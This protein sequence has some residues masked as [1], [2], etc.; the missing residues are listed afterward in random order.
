M[1]NKNEQNA[2]ETTTNVEATENATRQVVTGVTFDAETTGDAQSPEVEAEAEAG[3]PAEAAPNVGAAATTEAAADPAAEAVAAAMGDVVPKKQS[4]KAKLSSETTA[5]TDDVVPDYAAL[6]VAEQDVPKYEKLRLRF[7]NLGRLETSQVF[8]RG[9]VVHELHK[10]D[11]D[12]KAFAKSAKAVLGLSRTGA[13]NYERVHLYLQPHRARLVKVA[14]IASAL[15]NLAGA[16]PEKVEEVLAARES[17]VSLT[18]AQI[19]AMLGKTSAAAAPDDGGP[20]GLRAAV[21]EKTGY[22]SKVF[23]ETV[24]RMLRAVHIALEPHREGRQ[25]NKGKAVDELMHDARLASGL[26]KS[27]VYAAQVPG[28]PYGAGI[29]HVLPVA[30]NRWVRTERVL[31]DM[32]SDQSWPKSDVNRHAILTP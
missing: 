23:F 3:T 17:G 15:Y 30:E 32:G 16:E 21:A 18:G 24:V 1:A 4:R 6:G 13:E 8:E 5:T 26:L 10:L 14:M 31:Y 7:A 19:K 22:A 11:P 9:E 28:D 20:E 2:V 29:I 12:Q 25:V 27:L